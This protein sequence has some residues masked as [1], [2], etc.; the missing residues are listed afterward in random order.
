MVSQIQL[1]CFNKDI[2]R[3]SPMPLPENSNLS[4]LLDMKNIDFLSVLSHLD[5]G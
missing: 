2:A 4:S 5:D 1:W 3:N